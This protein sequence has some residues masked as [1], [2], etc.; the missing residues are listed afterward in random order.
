MKVQGGSTGLAPLVPQPQR[1]MGVAGQSH[2]PAALTPGKT[3]Y[4]LYR[5]LG[6][7]VWKGAEK[8]ALTGIRSPDRPARSQPLYGL[9][10]NGPLLTTPQGVTSAPNTTQPNTTQHNTTHS[11]PH[12]TVTCIVHPAFCMCTH[13]FSQGFS[14]Q[15]IHHLITFVSFCNHPQACFIHLPSAFSPLPNQKFLSSFN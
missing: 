6:R 4:T 8:L 11:S 12:T 10:R 2:A 5:R 7:P 14:R 13:T 9:K 1:L 15:R 3:R